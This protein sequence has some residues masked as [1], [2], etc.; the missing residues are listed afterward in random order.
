MAQVG[1]IVHVESNR[2]ETDICETDWLRYMDSC[3]SCRT[4]TASRYGN[5]AIVAELLAV[6]GAVSL[7]ASYRA[8]YSLSRLR[9]TEC[10]A[11]LSASASRSR[12]PSCAW[13][14]FVVAVEG[15]VAA[16]AGVVSS[17]SSLDSE[18]DSESDSLSSADALLSS[19]VLYWLYREHPWVTHGQ[20]RVIASIVMCTIAC[21]RVDS[22]A[23][24]Q[25]CS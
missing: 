11:P 13:R 20:E 12:L 21:C 2:W 10:S 3:V 15:L 7:T 14:W 25:N 17:S 6:I 16:D 22:L 18:S 9:L 4:D 1:W 5:D 23:L 24:R 8:S 19:A